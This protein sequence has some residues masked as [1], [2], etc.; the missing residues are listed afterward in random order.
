LAEANEGLSDVARQLTS[1]LGGG[2]VEAAFLQM[3][4]PDLR[5]AVDR[6][7]KAGSARIAVLP[8]FLFPGA[9]VLEDIPKAVDALRR[10]YPAVEIV[11][12]PHLGAHPKLAEI[13]AERLQEVF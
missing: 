11:L 8:F 6:C 1:L 10:A 13:A 9:H 7:V 2:R 12:A 5:E 3:A 4:Q